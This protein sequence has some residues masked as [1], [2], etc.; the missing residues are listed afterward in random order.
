MMGG[1]GKGALII[2]SKA[3]DFIARKG[4]AQYMPVLALVLE[5]FANLCL[6]YLA[7]PH[8]LC[9][10]CLCSLFSASL[11]QPSSPELWCEPQVSA[12]CHGR[13]T[14]LQPSAGMEFL[15]FCCNFWFAVASGCA[16][17]GLLFSLVCMRAHTVPTQIIFLRCQKE[18]I[19]SQWKLALKMMFFRRGGGRVSTDSLLLGN[20][21]RTKK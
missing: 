18:T 21:C 10:A 9:C 15:P 14:S 16:W 4:D 20:W 12:S 13:S 5:S 6:V 7:C 19:F 8:P 2:A 11:L 1:D 17:L 3:C